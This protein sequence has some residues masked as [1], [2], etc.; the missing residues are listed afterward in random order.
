[1]MCNQEEQCNRKTCCLFIYYVL[2]ISIIAPSI[3]HSQLVCNCFYGCFGL[4]LLH[5][6]VFMNVS[7][8]WIILRNNLINWLKGSWSYFS[9]IRVHYLLRSSCVCESRYLRPVGADP[10]GGPWGPLF[11]R[12]QTQPAVQELDGVIKDGVQDEAEPQHVWALVRPRPLVSSVCVPQ[13]SSLRV[14]RVSC[15]YFV[16][17]SR[18]RCGSPSVSSERAAATVF[19][20]LSCQSS[21]LHH[22]LCF[23]WIPG[24]LCGSVWRRGRMGRSLWWRTSLCE[25]LDLREERPDTTEAPRPPQH[26]NSPRSNREKQKEITLI[27]HSNHPSS[28]PEHSR[29]HI[30]TAQQSHSNSLATTRNTPAIT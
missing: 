5:L 11:W 14:C 24:F 12:T 28:H 8:Q 25:P 3:K 29:N 6:L 17:L 21:R 27:N 23:L 13:V 10:S 26:Q 2:V 9:H 4:S 19:C 7:K 16:S 18:L 1:M 22:V 15:L 30:V 20:H